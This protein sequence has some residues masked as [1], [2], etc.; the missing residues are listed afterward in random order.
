MLEHPAH[1]V[2]GLDGQLVAVEVVALEQHRLGTEDADAQAGDREAGLVVVQLAARLHDLGVDDGLGA[3]VEVV[4]EQAPL[5]PDLGGGQ[6]GADRLVHGLHHVVDQLHQGAVDVVDRLGHLAQHGVAVGADG[7]GGHAPQSTAAGRVPVAGTVRRTRPRRSDV[8]RVDLDPQPAGRA[9][10][11]RPGRRHR[12]AWSPARTRNRSSAERR[13]LERPT[14]PQ[15]RGVRRRPGAPQ[16]GQGP[17]R[18]Q[19]EL[20]RGPAARPRPA[21]RGRRGRRRPAPRGRARGSGPAPGPPPPRAP[22][23]RAA[24]ASRA[25]A[26]SPA[27]NRGAS[28]CWSKSR[29]ATRPAWSTRWRA[30]SVPDHQAGAARSPA[31]DRSAVTS[32]AGVASRAASS[33]VARDTPIRSALSRVES[34]TAHTAGRRLAAPPAG[35]HARRSRP[36][37]PPR[38]SGCS[39]PA[40]RTSRQASSRMRPVRLSTQTTRPP[41]RSSSAW[42]AVASRSENSPVRG[43]SPVR[44]TTSTTGQPRRSTARSVVTSGRPSVSASG[45]HGL[46]QHHRGPVAAAPLDHH[47]HRR[48]GRGPLLAVGLVVGVEHHG[49]A[50]PVDRGPGRR[51]GSRP[52]RT[53]RRP[54]GG[55]V[56]GQQGHRHAGARAAA[57]PGARPG[58]GTAAT[59]RTPSGPIRWTSSSTSRVVSSAGARRTTDGPPAGQRRR[60]PGPPSRRRA[61]RAAGHRRRCRRRGPRT[62]PRAGTPCPGTTTPARPTATPPTRPGPPPPAAGRAR[63][64][65]ARSSGCTPGSGVDVVLD[66]PGGHPSAVQRDADPA[67]HGRRRRPGAAG[68]A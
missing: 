49:G 44:S 38:R 64:S 7:V 58:C 55:P 18:R 26:S 61:R 40:R 14:P 17:E 68:T 20:A 66:H 24:R 39:G 32:T 28:R 12:T 10:D 1:E 57:R 59:T 27:P 8:G 48:P 23:T 52:S 5:D 25:S 34:H 21:G 33:S 29:K 19:A 31:A 36:G 9:R 53:R 43:S 67:A 50:Q 3:V 46:H 45:G 60:R 30:A 51:P 15:A 11:A 16:Q 54:G 4:D 42:A 2:V 6:A 37:P 65:A 63:S 13:H 22:T 47:V 56:V 35:Q 62:H 41:G